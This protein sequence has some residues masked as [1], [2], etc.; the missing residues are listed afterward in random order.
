[1]TDLLPVVFAPGLGCTGRLFEPQIGALAGRAAI[2][3][4]HA[5]HA[6]VGA[7]AAQ[8]LEELPPRFAL[9][10]LSMG[11]YVA[12]EV[13]RRAPERVERLAL[14]DTTAY[15][16]TE[17]SRARRRTLIAA[18]EKGKLAA[19][20]KATY[21]RYVNAARAGDGRL[22]A[23]VRAM[24]IETGAPAFVRQM[25]AILNRPD[26]TSLP[27]SIR[28]PTLVIVGEDDLPTPAEHARRMAAAIPDAALVV[29]PGVGHLSTLEDPKGVNAALMPFL[30][31]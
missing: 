18:A 20:H 15:P 23:I 7:I 25:T 13:I 12:F 1:M 31:T 11:G 3:L 6:D 30:A 27:P 16:D 5:R 26:Q 22:E 8:A 2:V 28:C 10:G 14:L 21:A 19:I 17:E 29:L 24:L 9:V 4:D